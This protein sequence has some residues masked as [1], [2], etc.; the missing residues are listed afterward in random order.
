[1]NKLEKKMRKLEKEFEKNPSA[2]ARN[3]RLMKK[4]ARILAK[5]E[6][7]NKE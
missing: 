3:N 5:L 7:R 1:M 2:T 6:S 4:A